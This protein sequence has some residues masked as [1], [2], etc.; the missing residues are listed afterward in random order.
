MKI[1]HLNLLISD[2]LLFNYCKTLIIKQL[3]FF[4][5]YIVNLDSNHT[6]KLSS[7][8]QVSMTANN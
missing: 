8:E 7:V 1:W 5:N 4:V 6:N 2:T 3:I